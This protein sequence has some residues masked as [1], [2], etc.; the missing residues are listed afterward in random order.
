[1]PILDPGRFNRP[2]PG[3][4]K[5]APPKKGLARFFEIMGRDFF[6]LF[7]LNL[8]VLLCLFPALLAVSLFALADVK[9]LIW[10]AVAWVLLIPAG[11]AVAAMNKLTLNM[12]RDIPCF[13][14][15]VFKK[16]YKQNAKQGIA[17]ILLFGFFFLGLGVAAMD[18][19]MQPEKNYVMLAIIAMALYT[20]T[21]IFTFTFSQIP[22]VDLRFG[23]IVKNAVLLTLGRANRGVPAVLI[24]LLVLGALIAFLPLSGFIFLFGVFSILNLTANLWVWPALQL[25]LRDDAQAPDEAAL[26]Q[27]TEPRDTQE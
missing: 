11:P 13:Q 20:V 12:V 23:A 22:V 18:W 6:D 15:E 1:M 16:A 3:V 25:V 24:Q 19:L 9:P 2:G 7:K 4:A 8:L 21:S 27:N 17:A 5:D 10:L 14:W 26:A